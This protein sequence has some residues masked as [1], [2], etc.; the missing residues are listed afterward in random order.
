VY[1]VPSLFIKTAGN[2]SLGRVD[3]SRL[4]S[5]TAKPAACIARAPCSTDSRS[6]LGKPAKNEA[7]DF[8]IPYLLQH[9]LKFA[10]V[11]H[12][13]SNLFVGVVVV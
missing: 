8:W 10:T 2:N 3:G 6:V 11:F 9:H 12:L 4:T 7:A 5:F 1:A 13:L